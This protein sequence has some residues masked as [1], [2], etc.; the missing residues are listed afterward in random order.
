MP[1]PDEDLR[2]VQR[3]ALRQ[4][5]PPQRLSLSTWIEQ[6]IRLPEGVSAEPGAVRLWPWQRA[7]ADAIGDP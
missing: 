4:W 7:I 6:N 2:A 5:I 3:R 1:M